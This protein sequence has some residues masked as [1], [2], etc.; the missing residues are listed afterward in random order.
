M[1]SFADNSGFIRAICESFCWQ[2]PCIR[3]RGASQLKVLVAY[4]GSPCAES[5][6]ED[7]RRA[8]LPLQAEALVLSVAGAELHP[9][10]GID[11]TELDVKGKWEQRFAEAE[12]LAETAGNRI[13]SYFPQWR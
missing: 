2:V 9:L 12:I 11:R 13:Q 8:G 7:M 3:F 5:A 6:I 1:P 10:P 4:D